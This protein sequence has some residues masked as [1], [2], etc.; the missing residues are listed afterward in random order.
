MQKGAQHS[1]HLGSSTKGEQLLE[2][3]Q[4]AAGGNWSVAGCEQ[5]GRAAISP[6]LP[7]LALLMA[8]T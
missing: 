6:T 5:V 3:A 8:L 4:Q 1:C 2:A 7:Q